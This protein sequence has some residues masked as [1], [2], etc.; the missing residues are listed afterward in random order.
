MSREVKVGLL[1]IIAIFFAIWGYKFVQGQNLFED[2]NSYYTTF[3]DVTALAA[4]SPVLL[5]GFKVGQVTAIKLNKD[6]VKKMDVHFIIDGGIPIPKNA[7]VVMKSEGIVGGKILTVEFDSPCESGDCAPTGSF[8]EG[9]VLGL[10]GSM[11][12]T[13]EVTEYMSEASVGIQEIIKTLGAEGSEGKVNDIVR[14]LDIAIAR[15]A[16]LSAASAKLISSSNSSING[17][18]RNL[19]QLSS[20][21]ADNNKEITKILANV[22]Q[23]TE[24]LSKVD[25]AKTTDNANK[26]M[27]DAS[28]TMTEIKN[29]LTSLESTIQSVSSLGSKM[30]NGEGTMGKLMNDK[31][32][33]ENLNTTSRQLSLL[34]QDLRLNPKRYV[35]VS[36]FG[37]KQQYVHPKD[38]PANK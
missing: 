28:S 37:R 21:I 4:S 18:L 30:D 15:I 19:D 5:N 34:L 10:L 13:D 14:N 20:T 8:I 12:G 2:N 22:E 23:T 7:S 24:G 35:N 1:A 16:D 36:V 17:I 33:Y 29:T 9:R 6:D 32:L 31:E 3:S 25:Y 27:Q 26:M 38:D 11:V